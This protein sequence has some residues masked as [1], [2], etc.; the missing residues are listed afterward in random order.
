MNLEDLRSPQAAI[1]G[2][3]TRCSL[4]E[5]GTGVNMLILRVAHNAGAVVPQPHDLIFL[6]SSFLSNHTY[7]IG[8]AGKDTGPQSYDKYPRYGHNR[9]GLF[10]RSLT[11]PAELG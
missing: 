3:T 11:Y 9:F 4:R 6:G 8:L 7:T 1:R 2:F 5:E 10:S